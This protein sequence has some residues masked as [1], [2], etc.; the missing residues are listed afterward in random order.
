MS[1]SQPNRRKHVRVSVDLE[2]ELLSGEKRN[3]KGKC[4][5][6]SAKGM[7]FES[8]QRFET[9]TIC[10]LVIYT[11]DERYYPTIHL[12]GKVMRTEANGFGIEFFAINFQDF[13]ALK[14]L[15]IFYAPDPEEAELEFQ[16]FL[17]LERLND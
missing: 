16:K 9:G 5:N 4:R 13:D 12:R 17:K 8:Y 2:V 6:L 1:S 11:G 7:L 15:I 14:N 3:L 10:N